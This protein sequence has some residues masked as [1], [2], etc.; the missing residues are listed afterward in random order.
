MGAGTASFAVAGVAPDAADEEQVAIN[1]DVPIARHG[2]GLPEAA[3][4]LETRRALE[5]G[6]SL[7]VDGEA[8][9]VTQ[10][11]G[12]VADVLAQAE[13]VLDAEDEVSHSLSAPVEPGMTIEV[14]TVDFDYLQ[15]R[16][17]DEYETVEEPDSTMLRGQRRVVR[18]GRNGERAATY[19]VHYRAGEEVD[20]EL[21]ADVELGERVDEV[22]RVGT[23]EPRPTTPPATTNGG[24]SSGGSAPAVSGGNPR[25]IGAELAAA[26]GWGGN[27]FSCLDRLWTR[28]S[29]WNPRAQNPSSGAYGIPQSLP[30]SKMASAGADWRTNPATQITW[31]L[32]YIAGRYGTPCAAWAHSQRVGW[33]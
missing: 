4:R 8:R 26:R 25:A 7:I 32:N 30:A 2:D 17:V 23:A 28:E 21:V 18:E 6:V 5:A 13:V 22:V 10:G 20:R 14:T 3:S 12:T 1:R 31:G 11:G 15:E 27:E 19:R 33:Y 16:E 24:G 29:N 9:E